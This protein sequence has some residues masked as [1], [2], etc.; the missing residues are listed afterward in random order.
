[1]LEGLFG[2]YHSSS[3]A[4][5]NVLSCQSLL[6]R[7]LAGLLAYQVAVCRVQC[8]IGS[9]LLSTDFCTLRKSR[10]LAVNLQFFPNRARL[11]FHYLPLYSTYLYRG[12]PYRRLRI[13]NHFFSNTASTASYSFNQSPSSISV[14]S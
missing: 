3:V 13:C 4:L 10:R 12:F 11:I 1:M 5:G 2:E 7:V 14:T 8:S 6:S 9:G